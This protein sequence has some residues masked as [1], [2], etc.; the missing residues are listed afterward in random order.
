M[1]D[2]MIHDDTMGIDEGDFKWPTRPFRV[3]MGWDPRDAYAYRVASWSLQKHASIPIEIIP[4]VD[5]DLRNRG[6]YWRSYRV[7]HKGQMWD[8]IDQRPFST[9]FSFSRFAVPIIEDYRDEWVLFTDPDVLWRSDV[10]ELWA[11]PSASE[12]AVNCVKHQHIPRE[13]QKMDGV[14]QT[15]Y[16]RKNWSSVMLINPARCQAMTKYVLNNAPGSELHAF[17]WLPDEAIGSLP[18]S[19]NW[20]EGHSSPKIEPHLVH[21]T[22]GDP[23]MPGHEDAPYSDEWWAIYREAVGDSLFVPIAVTTP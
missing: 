7:D 10:A 11:W 5:R 12:K 17:R 2:G 20:L 1:N 8:D 6:I 16:E 19:W 13:N 22:R 3:Y 4:V 9:Q 23:S 18:E 14:M 15:K 21:Y